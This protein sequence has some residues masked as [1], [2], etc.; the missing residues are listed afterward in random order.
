MGGIKDFIKGAAPA[1]IVKEGV[2]GLLDGAGGIIDKFVTDPDKKL[3]AEMELARLGQETEK[4]LLE[5]KKDAR[6]SEIQRINSD[7]SWLTKN[8][9]SVLAV[10][11]I[12]LSFILFG[13]LALIKVEVQQKDIII[14]VLGA[15][16][17]Y[18]GSIIQYYFGSSK[19]SVDK[20]DHLN[21][22]INKN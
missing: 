9:N 12:A 15:L 11:I 7:G 20:T 5:D 17:T 6:S 19:G 8:L 22:M 1:E 21:R 10:G 4:L 18:V 13:I 2:K 14:Y 3:E 16:T